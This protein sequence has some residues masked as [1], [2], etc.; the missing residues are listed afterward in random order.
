MEAYEGEKAVVSNLPAFS[1]DGYG[2]GGGTVLTIGSRSIVFG[3]GQ[4]ANKLAV[5]IARRWNG[6]DEKSSPSPF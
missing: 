6:S 1:G 5:E 3:E 2:W 4:E